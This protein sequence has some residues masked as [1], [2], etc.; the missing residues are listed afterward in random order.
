MEKRYSM[1]TVGAVI[2]MTAMAVQY[3]ARKL[4]IETQVGVTAEEVRMIRDYKPVDPKICRKHSA[5]ELM[6]ELEAIEC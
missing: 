4:G 5:K 1:R 2:G 3:R 6:Q